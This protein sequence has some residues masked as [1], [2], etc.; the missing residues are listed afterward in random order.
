M[1]S[2]SWAQRR[3]V[4][5]LPDTLVDDRVVFVVNRVHYNHNATLAV[6]VLD[7]VAHVSELAI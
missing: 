5:F 7:C 2:R 3:C 1:L 6:K 4:F